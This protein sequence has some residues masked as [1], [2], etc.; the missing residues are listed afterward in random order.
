M[1]NPTVVALIFALVGT[2]PAFAHA[3]LI[4]ETPADKAVVTVAPT[5]LTLKFS[6]G[7]ALKFT[8]VKVIGADDAPVPLG[9]ESLD[10]NDGT[11]LTVPLAAVLAPGVYSVAWHT[12]SNDGHKS[13]GAY[14]FTVK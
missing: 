9:T 3:H 1:K 4:S 5:I 14:T 2:A 10:P 6:E 7:V 8:G 13:S 12:L 11:A